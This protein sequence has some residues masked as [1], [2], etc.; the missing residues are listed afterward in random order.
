MG[1]EAVTAG[2]TATATAAASRDGN[3]NQGLRMGETSARVLG[4]RGQGSSG[5]R[6]TTPQPTLNGRRGLKKTRRVPVV[7]C[8][9][10][11]AGASASEVDTALLH[12]PKTPDEL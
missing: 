3:S 12:R 6:P 4:V 11:G 8:E 10:F 2:V 7:V 9:G 5:N 1:D